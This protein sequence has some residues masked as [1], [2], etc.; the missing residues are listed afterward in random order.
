MGEKCARLRSNSTLTTLRRALSQSKL[1]RSSSF[2][3]S[4]RPG[5]FRRQ[6][7]ERALLENGHISGF[8]A[9]AAASYGFQAGVEQY[10]YAFFFIDH[11]SLSYL[12]RSRGWAVGAG[13]SLTIL[14]NGFTKPF[15][16]TDLKSGVYSVFFNQQGLDGR[17]RAP[18][19][20]D[21]PHCSLNTQR[22]FGVKEHRLEK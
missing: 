1:R 16:T 19:L 2:P 3:I 8:Y 21:H 13:P 15:S 22:G 17:R 6:L 10:G 5:C 4:S 14:N 9:T 7:G 12:K 18:G 20:K 11:A